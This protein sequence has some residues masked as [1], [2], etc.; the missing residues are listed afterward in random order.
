MPESTTAAEATSSACKGPGWLARPMTFSTRAALFSLGV[1]VPLLFVWASFAAWAPRPRWQS[2][3]L[4]D[5]VRRILGGVPV[6]DQNVADRLPRPCRPSDRRI[7]TSQRRLRGGIASLCGVDRIAAC[8][9]PVNRQL[10]TRK[11]FELMLQAVAP[12]APHRLRH[13]YD[14]IGP[15]LASATLTPLAADLAFVG[16]KPA[17]WIARLALCVALGKERA[18]AEQLYQDA[19]QPE[20]R[21]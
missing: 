7:V 2:G 17:E 4:H 19:K 3:E 13:M 1:I 15:R 16:L 10:R 8:G 9:M 11:A 6:V 14:S 18:L 5:M 20:K 12:R 21:S